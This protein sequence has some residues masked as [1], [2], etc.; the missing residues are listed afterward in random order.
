LQG[1][2]RRC[3]FDKINYRMVA[4][5]LKSEPVSESIYKMVPS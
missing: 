4:S 1:T 5:Y 3:R 2:A